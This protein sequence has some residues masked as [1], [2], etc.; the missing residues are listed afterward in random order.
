M[1]FFG[2]ILGR[3]QELVGFCA[4]ILGQIQGMVGFCDLI[5]GFFLLL[6]RAHHLHLE[7]L[8]AATMAVRVVWVRVEQC[9]GRAWP[10]VPQ[11]VYRCI[12]RN[13]NSWLIQNLMEN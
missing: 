8:E 5:L 3:A 9:G 13:V 2:L 11:G 1:G 10:L 6:G 4:L 7:R 12:F